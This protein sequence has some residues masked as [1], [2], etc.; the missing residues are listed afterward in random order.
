MTAIEHRKEALYYLVYMG[1]V[2]PSFLALRL[3]NEPERT[4]GRFGLNCDQIY[5]PSA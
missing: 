1:M 2:C 5:I 3:S 4:F